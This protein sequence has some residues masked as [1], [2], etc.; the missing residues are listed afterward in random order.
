MRSNFSFINPFQFFILIFAFCLGSASSYGQDTLPLVSKTPLVPIRDL[1]CEGLQKS[2]RDEVYKKAEWKNL[3]L[4]KKMAI[5]IVDLRDL[6]NIAYAGLN[7]DQMMYAA[8]LP[9]IAVLLGAFDAIHQGKIEYSPE[10][11]EDLRL[12]ISKS[13]NAATTRVIDQ[14]G[15]LQ[16]ES[17]LRN[18]K[19]K[20]YDEDEGGGLW[21]GKR[22]ARE[23]ARYPD[24]LKGMSH[25]A[26]ASQAASFY[27]QLAFGELIDRQSSSEMLS[28]LKDPALTHKFVNSLQRIA[29]EA[30]LYRKSGS[31][32]RFHSDSVLVWGPDRRYILVALI[33]DPN[34]EQIIRSLVEPLE[35]V[36]ADY[37]SSTCQ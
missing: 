4:S 16:I 6:S 2:L 19:H 34:G 30:T 32:K 21:V 23:G 10:L 8:S 20:L 36:L 33:E 14:I 37:A 5:G 1:R 12:M 13:N 24:P 26:T 18:A 9:K 31:W 29:P 28:M 22:Y 27:Y 7:D 15:Y 25:G 35:E 3:V 17:A 11:K